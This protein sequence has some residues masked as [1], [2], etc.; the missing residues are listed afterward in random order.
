MQRVFNLYRSSVGKKVM[1]AATG[2]IFFLFVLLH[3]FGN[4][5]AFSGAEKFDH[6]AESLREMGAPILGHG[7]ALWIV[8]VVLLLA[9]TVH[10]VAA[11]QLWRMSK[12]ARP[13]PYQH[14]LE[15]AA[16]TYASRTMRWGGVII[17]LFVVYHLL[18][19]TT[20]SVHPDFVPGSAYHNLVVGFQSWPVAVAYIVA[21]CALAM[22]VY[23]GVW[24]GLQTIGANHPRYNRLR[25]PFAAVVAVI[26]FL[27][28]VSIPVSVL[29]GILT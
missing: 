12:S 28:F 13:V 18:H 3:M 5:K 26:I 24:S 4:L 29:A 8:R 11:V 17:F 15:H 1:M 27:G 19:F 2:V 20:G 6:Y 7:Q 22:H 14:G 10:V 16:S 9:V 23:H 25:R 21:M